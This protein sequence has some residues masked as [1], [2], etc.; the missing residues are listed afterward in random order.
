MGEIKDQDSASNTSEEDEEL[1]LLRLKRMQNILA[2]KQREE[3]MKKQQENQPSMHDKIDLILRTVL[4][5]D[6]YDYLLKIKSKDQSTYNTIVRILLPPQVLNQLDTLL[7][8]RRNGMLRRGIISLIDIQLLERQI[9]GIGP[10][11][12]I[13]K[14]G[15]KSKSLS[16]FLKE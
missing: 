8:Y 12:T 5:S 16:D 15:E 9:L 7:V 13:K 3:L 1:R 10:Q 4:A 14:T 2:I 11:I 6:A